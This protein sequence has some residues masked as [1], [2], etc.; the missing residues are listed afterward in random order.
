MKMHGPSYKKSWYSAVK[1]V[2]VIQP[3]DKHIIYN[4]KLYQEDCEWQVGWAMGE[5]GIE[6]LIFITGTILERNNVANLLTG[7]R[8]SFD[9]RTSNTRTVTAVPKSKR[10]IWNETR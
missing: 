9:V 1:N 10:S 7:Q 6:L 5:N 8:S 3:R 4:V 2:L